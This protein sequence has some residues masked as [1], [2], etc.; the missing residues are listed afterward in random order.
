MP[1]EDY[2]KLNVDLLS[3]LIKDQV[4]WE[5]C[6]VMMGASSLLLVD[7]VYIADAATLRQSYVETKWGSAPPIQK[8]LI[9]F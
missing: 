4:Q 6:F 7:V 2:V 1:A 9:Y 8:C 3:A 5:Q